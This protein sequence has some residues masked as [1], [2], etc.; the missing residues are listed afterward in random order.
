MT[1]Q[2]GQESATGDSGL[3]A[4]ADRLRDSAKWL[5]ASF[6]AAA[7]VVLVGVSISDLERLS[8]DTPG[9]RLAI[10][11][12]GAVAGIVGTLG[13]LSQAI[14]LAAASSVTVEDLRARPRRWRRSLI[15]AWKQVSADPALK[16]WGGDPAAFVKE[17]DEARAEHW[18]ERNAHLGDSGSS[19]NLDG[20]NRATR[21]VNELDSLLGRFLDY[22]SFLRIQ[23]SFKMAR[24]VIVAWLLFA[25]LGI[26]AF[27]YAVRSGDV[28]TR[29][30]VAPSE[31]TLR[32]AE[33]DREY[34][35]KRIGADCA[36][37]LDAVPV[38]VLEIDAEAN[39]ADVVSLPSQGCES[40]RRSVP[41]D[42]LVGVPED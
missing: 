9:Y 5:I 37:D 29:V 42:D 16:P 6:G 11:I 41:R 34:I 21:A 36:Y 27:V 22:A 18:R 40:V 30:P 24:W 20:L 26:L 8:G 12:G 4:A 33:D 15:F 10:A 2:D 14:S 7:A 32:I 35:E 1:T 3:R 13:A 19:P 39:V 31:A 25:G 28:S 38:L 23:K 17:L